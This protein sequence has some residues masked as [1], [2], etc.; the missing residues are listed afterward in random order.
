MQSK[1]EEITEKFTFGNKVMEK[2]ENVQQKAVRKVD[3]TASIM[4]LE[5]G[6][7][8]TFRNAEASPLSVKRIMFDIAKKHGREYQME[9]LRKPTS[10]VTRTK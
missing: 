5:V 8:V 4:Q 3:I 9:Y 2:K 10:T 1:G 7:A 6:E